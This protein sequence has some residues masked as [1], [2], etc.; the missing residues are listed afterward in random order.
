[1]ILR[2]LADPE[3]LE[4]D[5]QVALDRVQR[6]EHFVG[7]L[8]IG[9]RGRVLAALAKRPAQSDQDAALRIGQLGQVGLFRGG[10][11]R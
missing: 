8:L 4:Q 11:G 2:E 1:L 7:D 5:A 9:C 10:D 3:L 6:E